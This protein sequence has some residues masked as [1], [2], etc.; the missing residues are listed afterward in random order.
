MLPA[1]WQ[2]VPEPNVVADRSLLH[3]APM[4]EVPRG[5]VRYGRTSGLWDSAQR[6]D[7]QKS[8]GVAALRVR[9]T[10]WGKPQAKE[11][12]MQATVDLNPWIADLRDHLAHGAMD[13][14]PPV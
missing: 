7:R 1:C 2:R 13:G 14:L 8:T 12:P 4:V 6:E 11:P 5:A 3:R 10:T 9:G